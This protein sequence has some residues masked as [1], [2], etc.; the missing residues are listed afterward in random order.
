MRK[1]GIVKRREVDL[2]NKLSE[3]ITVNEALEIVMR[4]YESEGYRERTVRDYRKF[5]AQFTD[6]IKRE[7]IEKVTT[8]DIRKYVHH[9]LH[10]RDLSAVTVNIRLSAVRAIFNRL[11]S[12]E[13][14]EVNP[15]EKVRKLRTDQ[16]RIFTLTDDQIR[17]LFA[18]IDKDTFTG[19]RD[20]C[21][22]LLALK[23]G[24]RSNELHSLETKDV[25]LD[26]GVILLPGAKNKNRKT[27]MVP[28]S[29]KV[30]QEL[31]QLIAETRE[32]FGSQVTHVFTNQFGEPMKHELLRKRVDS[33]ARKAGLKGECRASLHSLRHTFA[34]NFLKNGGN[35]RTLMSILGHSDLSTTQIYLN[36]TD[37][38]VVEQYR[39]VSEKDTLDV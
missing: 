25:D 11:Y 39:E 29:K 10:T 3:G 14:I 18:M 1:R 38:Q 34:T 21:A 32:Y 6:I 8:E 5:W 30:A 12:E 36:Y 26:N 16:Q 7:Y 31:A 2:R 20:Y 28:M 22:F 4:I 37:E 24:L 23:C 13:I 35:I 27:R 19:Y 9:L 15:V 17:R 33:Y